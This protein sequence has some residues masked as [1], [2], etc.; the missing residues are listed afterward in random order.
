MWGVDLPIT[1]VLSSAWALGVPR[2]IGT[3][4][5]VS[6]VLSRTGPIMWLMHTIN[7][8]QDCV[9]FIINYKVGSTFIGLKFRNIHSGHS[10]WMV[11]IVIGKP[12]CGVQILYSHRA[13]V[14]HCGSRLKGGMDG[15]FFPHPF[16]F[17]GWICTFQKNTMSWEVWGWGRFM[18]MQA[19]FSHDPI[20]IYDMGFF[21]HNLLWPSTNPFFCGLAKVFSVLLSLDSYGCTCGRVH[22]CNLGW[23]EVKPNA[24]WARLVRFGAEFQSPC[25]F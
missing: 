25:K 22:H 3:Q 13:W 14:R 8:V 5:K 20:P 4:Q 10:F 23:T 16:S 18:T 6:T 21:V 15:Q 2:R 17:C 19:P 1:L 11:Q 12:H 7:N 24:I 9:V